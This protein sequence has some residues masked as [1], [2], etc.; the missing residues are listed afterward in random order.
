MN[1][2]TPPSPTLPCACAN[3]RRA[4][5]AVSR[6]YNG[7]LRA[8]GIEITQFTL[9][10]TLEMTGATPQGR[11]GELLELDSTTLTRMLG[12]IKRRGWVVARAGSDRR[13]RIFDLTA[14][15]RAQLQRAMVPWERAQARLRAG[16][17]EERFDRLGAELSAVARAAHAE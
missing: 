4:A 14:A 7:E 10:M 17:G 15:G 1:T 13:L 5:R 9:L 8:V 2:P 3:L 6:L 11:L 16:L 12:L